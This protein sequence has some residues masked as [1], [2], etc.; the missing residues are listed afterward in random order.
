MTGKLKRKL[1]AILSADVKGY[2][3]LMGEDEE[4]TLRTL[5]AYKEVITDFVQHHRGRVV[6]R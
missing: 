5:N 6:R 4:W 1:V 2:S 3:R